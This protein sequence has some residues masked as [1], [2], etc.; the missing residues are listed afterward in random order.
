LG[1][2]K[3]LSDGLFHPNDWVPMSEGKKI[4]KQL[5]VVE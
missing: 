3:P 1:I 2:M 4:F 5:G